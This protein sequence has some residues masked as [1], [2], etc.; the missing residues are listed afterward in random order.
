M[1]E[2]Y[3]HGFSDAERL[4]LIAQAQ[5][6]STPVFDGLDFS[7]A[8]QLLEVGCAV[9]AELHLIEQRAPHLALTGLDLSAQHLRAGHDWL[10]QR[11]RISLVQS[12]ASTLPFADDSFD[13][14]MTIWLLEHVRDAEV[15][16]REPLILDSL[17]RIY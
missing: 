14:G 2:H 12:D 4:R 13:I 8:Q 11:E 1:S 15:V 6:L 17:Y 9:G 16:I 7:D 10:A 5:M 3:I